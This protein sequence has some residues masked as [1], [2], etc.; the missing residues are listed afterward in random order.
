VTPFHGR[1]DSFPG[2]MIYNQFQIEL[3]NTLGLDFSQKAVKKL[4]IITLKRKPYLLTTINNDAAQVYQ[5]IK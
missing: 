2:A 5:L 1:F 4:S 3:G